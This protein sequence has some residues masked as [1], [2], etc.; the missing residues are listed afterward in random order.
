VLV[1]QG[2]VSRE[3]YEQLR[4][5]YDSLKATAEAARAAVHSADETTKVDAAAI[6]SAKVQL[7]YCYI[8][9]PLMAVP[10]SGLPTSARRQPR[11]FK[12]SKFQ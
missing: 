11:K 4:A 10:D 6:E 3:Q 2:V 9:R 12:Q 5:S 8:P 7:S 1:E